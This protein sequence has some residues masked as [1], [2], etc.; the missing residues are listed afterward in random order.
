[1]KKTL[2]FYTVITHLYLL[3][4]VSC[5]ESG[6]KKIRKTTKSTLFIGVDVSGSFTKTKMFKDGM[7]FLG[8]YIH[9]HLEN[10]GPLSRPV[11]LYVGGIGGNIKEDPQDFFP[12]HDFLGLSPLKIEEKLLKE[13]S[14]Q[15]DNLTDFNTFFERTKSIVKQKNLVF[16]PLDILLVTDGIPEIAGKSKKAIKQGYSKINLKPIEYL[17]RNVSIRIL[18]AGARVGSH[19]RN[20][21][22]TTRIKVWTVEPR[23]MYGWKTQQGRNGT[24]GLLNWIRDNIDLKIKSRGV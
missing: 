16:S 5:F 21:V 20:Y 6:E 14:K 23:V 12:I 4:L 11:D 19:W 3:N 2:F 18:Y 1:M 15:R 9:H 7:K 8:V 24:K 22:P 13:F 17:T 10:K